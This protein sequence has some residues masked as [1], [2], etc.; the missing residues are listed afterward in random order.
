MSW[1]LKNINQ[2]KI[3]KYEILYL[4]IGIFLSLLMFKTLMIHT[5]NTQ[6]TDKVHA[7][8]TEGR[9]IHHGNAATKM[10]ALPGSFLTV[11]TAVPMMIW[12]SPYAA[13]L[14]IL[15]THFLS[16]L[17]LRHLGFKYFNSFNPNYLA[18]IYWLNPWRIEQSELYNPGYL[19]LFGALYLYFISKMAERRYF[20]D[21]F[22]LAV[23]VGFC[24]QVHFSVLIL[25]ISFLYLFFKKKISVHYVGFLAGCAVIGVS[26][27]PWLFEQLNGEVQSLQTHSGAYLGRNLVLVYPVIK[28]ALYFFRMGSL[29]CGRHIFSEIHF[30]YIQLQSLKM[31]FEY[32]F[33]SVKWI[34]AAVTLI[35]SFR[36]FGRLLKAGFKGDKTDFLDT[37]IFSIFVGVVLS[38]ALSP[39]EFNHWHFVLCFPMI[40]FVISGRVHEYLLL[41]DFKFKL[42]MTSLRILTPLLFIIWGLFMSFG[43]RSHSISND[44]HQAYLK[45]YY[46]K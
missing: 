23:S 11:V 22:W 8:L 35:L 30:E 45:K 43:S 5:D 34:M 41:N 40:V 20:W 16:Y 25:G 31:I 10:G 36:F 19:F 9:W 33:H 27:L 15:L 4:L 39:V 7:I 6:L 42:W 24:F 46:S 3:T 26:L 29:Y 17:L 2:Y 18:V 44:F 13:C 32:V 12:N 37:F 1:L 21:S 38:A 28:A 14:F